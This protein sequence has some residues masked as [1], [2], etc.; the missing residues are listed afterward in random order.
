MAW[1]EYHELTKHSAASLRRNQ[2]ALDWANM[3]DPF[4]HYQGAPVLDLPADPPPP[5]T[6]ALEILAG[7][8]GSTQTADG[9]AFLSQLMF[10][11][12]SI[13]AIKKVL[14]TGYTYA[15][16]VNPSS[17]NLHPTEFHFCTRG[18][19]HWPGGIY[20]YLPSSH[21]A[22]QRAIGDFSAQLPD[23][24]APLT[25]LLTSIVWREAWKYGDRAYRYCMHDIGHAWQ[26]LTLAARAMGCESCATGRFPDDSI[27]K[28]FLLAE[29]EWPMLLVTLTGPSIPV[30]TSIPAAPVLYGGQPNL[31]SA[32]QISYPS[33]ENI[34][35]ASKLFPPPTQS[36]PEI[37]SAHRPGEPGRGEIKLPSSISTE[38]TFADVVRTRRSALDF[39]G[40]A[41]T[42][43]LPQLATI[44][45]AA[46]HP[47]FA[48][49]STRRFVQLYLYVHRVTDLPPGVYRYWPAQHELEMIRQGDQ[50]LVAAALSLGQNLAGNACVAFS[51]IGDFESAANIHGDRG[52]RYVHF[53][54]G[55]IGQR[56]YLA[57]EALGL[58][59]TGI[60]AFF[61]NEV[62]RYLNLAPEQGQVVYHFAIGY[63]VTDPRLEP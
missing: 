36:A 23:A 56:M 8:L 52:V 49:F 60:G 11:S 40:G 14:S 5:R 4:R 26:A 34:H 46:A 17:G 22:E 9:A 28:S 63:P 15:L 50:R 30:H 48:D 61:D 1:R 45:A 25:F 33:I 54:A 47:F 3:P 19:S 10:Y 6:P 12:A 21:M 62:H 16:R 32:E 55:A 51:M 13:S 35:A 37:P 38:S 7:K 27:S 57:A 39:R 58:R 18:L 42:I 53:E 29:D 59:A 2:R 41:E 24:N 20:H 44:L 43:S 31:L